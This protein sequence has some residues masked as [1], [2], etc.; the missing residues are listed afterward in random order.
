[1]KFNS[2]K[3]LADENISPRILAFLRAKGIDAV[4]VKEKGWHGSTDRYVLEMAY[5]DERFVLTHDSDF[6]TL[7]IN[8][9]APCYGIIY[10]RLKNLK[11]ENVCGVLEKLSKIDIEIAKGSIVV[12]EDARV[13]IRSVL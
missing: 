11:V 4:D 10:I 1:M 8:E 9:G 2:V 6:G 7:A 5:A 3:I 12:V 13:R